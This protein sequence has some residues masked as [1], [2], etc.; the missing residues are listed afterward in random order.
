MP[1]AQ[2]RLRAV[3]GPDD[4]SRMTD[5]PETRY[6]RAP[7]GAY[8]AFQVFGS[9]PIDVLLMPGFVTN[10]DENWR[11]PEIADTHRRIGAFAR[12]I[13]MDRR[14][15]GLSDRLAH[16]Q[17]APL[18]THVD[19]LVA[20]LDAVGA[21]DVCLV[22]GESGGPLLALLFAAAHGDRVRALGLYAPMKTSLLAP[23]PGRDLDVGLEMQ[24]WGSEAF[25]R[26]DLELT[27][28][29]VAGDPVAVRSWG[30]YLRAAASPGSAFAMQQQWW[31]TEV[32]DV[33][34]TVRTPTLILTRPEAAFAVAVE[35]FVTELEA[36][37]P[38]VRV[39]EL[40]GRDFLYWYGDRAAFVA[41]LE[42]FFTGARS[43]AIDERRGLATVLFTDIVGSTA[44]SAEL[45]DHEWEEVRAR[46][47]AIVRRVLGQHRG[48]E[49]KTMGDGFLA[50]FD[51]PARAVRCAR[52]IVEEVQ[53]LGIEI[54]AGLHTGEITRELD[55]IS[56]IAVAIGARTSA[57]AGPSEVLVSSTVR[58]LVAGSGLSFVDAGEHELKGVPDRWHLYRAVG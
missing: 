22:S 41:E 46:H 42:E 25:V 33:L 12:V 43:S 54:R 45:G 55:D 56:G 51:G 29:S 47:D 1:Y 17:G 52:A 31:D 50:T 44:R 49:I 21:K 13:A 4:T 9:G 57:L 2:P 6:T 40:P 16:G 34:P 23:V 7:D 11:I 20:V 3:C 27:A 36:G 18:E 37:L 10:L 15:V 28:P 39:V 35:P 38:D 26:K 5:P 48:I 19:D 53:L 8:L 32:R 24:F 14:G 58:D 30:S